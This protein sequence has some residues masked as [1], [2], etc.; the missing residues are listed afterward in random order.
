MSDRKTPW[1]KFY[2][3]DWQSDIC[4]RSCSISARGLWVELLCIMQKS[5]P[6]G[7]LLVNG[8]QPSFTLLSTLCGVPER[9]VKKFLKELE[10]AGV[11]SRDTDGRIYSRRII[12]DEEKT[13]LHKR[14]GAK[15]G[16]PRLKQGVNPRDK[17]H[18]PEARSQKPESKNPTK[19]STV[20]EVIDYSTGE[21]LKC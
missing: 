19:G 9:E 18:I 20:S 11:F 12:R 13:E 6:K 2:P 1:F 8:V 15:G 14:N 21:V 5:E 16:N 3:G 17:A 7:Y 10:K 4:L